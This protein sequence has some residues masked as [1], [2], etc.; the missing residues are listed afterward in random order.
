MT[1]L[2]HVL[3]RV[4]CCAQTDMEYLKNLILQLYTTGEAE[5]LL[6]VFTRL[7]SLGPED[8]KRCKQ[9]RCWEH[10]SKMLVGAW[11]LAAPA[12]ALCGCA[13]AAWLAL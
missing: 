7:L 4:L 2:A 3:W 6:P 11:H 1:R 10:C 9:V 12:H 8:V 13:S 5:A